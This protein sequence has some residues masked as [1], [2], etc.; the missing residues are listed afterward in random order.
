MPRSGAGVVGAELIDDMNLNSGL[1]IRMERSRERRVELVNPRSR[2]PA[3]RAGTRDT[4]EWHW[5]R[6]RSRRGT[7]GQ[8]GQ[9]QDGR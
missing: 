1:D 5:E 8:P 3:A 7:R 2:A 6:G 9:G 4:G